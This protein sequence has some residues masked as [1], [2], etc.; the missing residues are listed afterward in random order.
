VGA[1]PSW[2]VVLCALV[3]VTHH[4]SSYLL[5]GLLVALVTAK[6]VARRRPPL[7]LVVLAAAAAAMTAGVAARGGKLHADLRRPV[8]LV[9]PDL[10]APS[11]S[12]APAPGHAA[13]RRLTLPVPEYER[14]A[15]FR[16]GDRPCSDCSVAG[17]ARDPGRP[18]PGRVVA[19]DR[20]GRGL[21][22]V[23]A[24]GGNAR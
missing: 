4:G 1:S 24:A 21:L 18:A 7:P 10:G 16:G 11:S 17:H 23:V 3:V 22:H 19:A 15:S 5:T 20:P 12:A 13:L 2:G 14:I 8:H 6:L 9:E